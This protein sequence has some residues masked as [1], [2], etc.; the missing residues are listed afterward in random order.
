MTHQF[1]T[2]QIVGNETIVAIEQITQH[3]A[4]LITKDNKLTFIGIANKP[5][6]YSRLINTLVLTAKAKQ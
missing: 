1:K 5:N 4:K 3:Y 6:L 2:L